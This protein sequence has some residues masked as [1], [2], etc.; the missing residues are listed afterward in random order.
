HRLRYGGNRLGQGRQVTRN[1]GIFESEMAFDIFPWSVPE[2]EGREDLP[3]FSQGVEPQLPP[4]DLLVEGIP[5]VLGPFPRKFC[6]F[7]YVADLT[8][9]ASRIKCAPSG[10]DADRSASSLRLWDFPHGVSSF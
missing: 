5:L 2:Q 4:R 3:K 8:W 1:P 9:S 6:H 7:G 10:F